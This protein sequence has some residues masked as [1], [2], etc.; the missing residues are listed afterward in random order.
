MVAPPFQKSRT[1]RVI[2]LSLRLCL[3]IDRAVAITRHAR[4]INQRIYKK[5]ATFV[6]LAELV[7]PTW[8]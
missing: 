5:Q 4:E 6:T 3:D 8:R 7:V 2:V 1:E